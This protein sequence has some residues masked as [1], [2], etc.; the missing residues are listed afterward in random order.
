MSSEYDVDFAV[1]NGTRLLASTRPELFRASLFDRRLEG[2]AYLESVVRGK[3]F[4]FLSELVGVIPYTVGYAPLTVEGKRVGVVA[5]PTLYRQQEIDE[6][7]AER[8]VG[9]FGV[10]AIVVVIVLA[11]GSVLASRI[12]GPIRELSVAARQVG[13]GEMDVPLNYAG[14]DEV[15]ELTSA[16]R[17]MTKELQRS[18]AEIVR[19]EREGAWKEMA[20]QVAHEIRNPLTPMKL[21][22]QHVR[23]A[24]QDNAANREELLQSVIRTVLEQIDALSRI[25]TEFSHFAKMPPPE[26]ARID[27]HSVLEESIGVFAGVEGIR[28]ERES[29]GEPC[30]LIADREHLRRVFMN[31]MRNSVQAMPA[32]GTIRAQTLVEGSILTIRISDNGP[33]IPEAIRK[34]IFEPNFSTKTE[35]MGLGL[36]ISR[37]II[38]DLG[39][40]IVCESTIGSG[41]T[42]V[43]TLV[44]TLREA[45]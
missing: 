9:V 43:I 1:Y 23:Q 40:T 39:G 12:A 45:E 35:G 31:I 19:A 37:K 22:I 26:Y 15:G 42:F 38:E 10:Y 11:G 21:A 17:E 27:V 34:R 24:F 32:G 7:V 5:I 28:F 3:P 14:A 8:N 6:E 36:A 29:A 4:A 16:F 33:G 20:K 30:I 18:R 41:T 2:L 44:R 13:K 25:A